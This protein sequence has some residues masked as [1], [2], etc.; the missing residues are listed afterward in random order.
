MILTIQIISFVLAACIL[1]LFV[2][3]M[4]TGY[5]KKST[6][7]LLSSSILI[8]LLVVATSVVFNWFTTILLALLITGLISILLLPRLR[9]EEHEQEESLWF[10]E[11]ES[12]PVAV[13]NELQRSEEELV[14]IELVEDGEKEESYEEEK[15]DGI[16]ED[17]NTIN[18]DGADDEAA[19]MVEIEERTE[20]E[21]IVES[22]PLNITESASIN[23]KEEQEPKPTSS[24]DLV[25]IDFEDELLANRRKSV[26]DENYTYP[27]SEPIKEEMPERNFEELLE[28]EDEEIDTYREEK[29]TEKRKID[30]DMDDFEI[31]EMD[32]DEGTNR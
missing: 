2:N 12:Q 29:K 17:Q 7:M 25:D 13:Q 26:D 30:I 1:I 6:W 22:P 4:R 10:E 28:L 23:G 16:N 9:K 20:E 5:D 14:E 15:Q 32:L 27:E 8:T 11:D 31:P 3:R 19:A 18:Y 24:A 21:P